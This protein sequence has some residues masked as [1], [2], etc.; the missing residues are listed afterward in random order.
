MMTTTGMEVARIDDQMLALAE[1]MV[2]VRDTVSD[3]TPILR[4]NYV[5]PIEGSAYEKGAWVLG[6]VKGENG[7][8]IEQG[9]RIE[10]LV[11]LCVRNR[12]SYYVQDD[13]DKNCSSPYHVIGEWVKG[14]RYRNDCGVNCAYTAK[15]LNPR[16]RRQK[17]LFGI[18]YTADGSGYECM[19]FMQ[20]ANFVPFSNFYRELTKSR[21]GKKGTKNIPPFMRPVVLGSRREKKGATTYFVGEYEM[22]PLF[23]SEQIQLF[24]ERR[25]LAA[26][27]ID[28]LN[29][30]Q[31]D[32]GVAK[33]VNPEVEVKPAAGADVPF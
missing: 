22:G 14:N 7:E 33:V 15:D 9:V 26:K 23:D 24:Q 25:N 21:G 4:L 16:C 2:D 6:Q 29:A 12:F 3:T 1:P 17:V 13:T 19:A 5:D 27:L 20:G 32:K 18:G 28:E 11:I 30:S 10:S 31:G 8:L